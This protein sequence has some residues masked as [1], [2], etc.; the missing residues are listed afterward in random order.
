MDRNIQ[1]GDHAFDYLQLL[2][3]LFA[4]EG[5]VR[6]GLDQK[7]GNDGGHPVEETGTGLPFQDIPQPRHRDLGG[8][9]VRVHFLDP[10]GEQQVG[11]LRFQLGGVGG[12]FPRIDGEILVGAE[13]FGIDEQGHTGARRPVQRLADQRQ[14]P[15][16]QGPHGRHQADR[17]TVTAPPADMGAQVRHRAD[18]FKR[19]RYF[20]F[21]GLTPKQCSGAGKVPARTSSEYI[22]AASAIP[23]PSSM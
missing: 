17:M 11:A 12:F 15:F 6:L 2:V 10:G 20:F 5:D 16:M 7:L 4:E 13:L 22:R 14:V 19:H 1:V 23:W 18:D 8:G 3:I 9:A 21:S